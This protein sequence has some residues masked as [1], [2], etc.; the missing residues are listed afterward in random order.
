MSVISV[1]V[2]ATTQGSA[3]EEGDVCVTLVGILSLHC[4][5]TVLKLLLH[6]CYTIGER[7]GDNTG[8]RSWSGYDVR[9]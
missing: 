8:E 2:L 9:E 1:S 4:Y 7:S 3:A 5:Y 6:C